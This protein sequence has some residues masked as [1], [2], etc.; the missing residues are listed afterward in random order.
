M[1]SVGK[2]EAEYTRLT[3]DLTM[4][5]ARTLAQANPAMRLLY[6]SGMG[7][8]GASM[9]ARVKGRVENDV[10]ALLPEAIMI[11]LAA[12]RPVHGERSRTPGGNVLLALLTPL[13]PVLQWSWPDGVITTEDGRAMIRAARDG[14]SKHVLESRDLIA[15]GRR[16]V[17][18]STGMRIAIW[19]VQLLL[20]LT[21]V[22]TAVWKLA[23][24]I[25]ELAAKMPWMGQKSSG[26]LYMTATLD[27]SC[28]IG[29]L[30]PSLTRIKPS[31]SVLAAFGTIGLM[32]GAIVFH[33]SR[34][35]ASNTPFNF[36]LI[37]LALFV[38]WGRG[39]KAPIAARAAAQPSA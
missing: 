18:A 34:G 32:I 29:L 7:T 20:G 8:G 26:F 11:R 1:S 3:Y 35:E 9:W 23:T 39:A 31:L 14:G 16:T 21:F 15:L 36:L 4:A 5:W 17:Q 13:W 38:A 27:L 22:G 12:M 10:K 19:T 6:V 25:P 30:L 33:V 24:P 2:T 28:G 37:A